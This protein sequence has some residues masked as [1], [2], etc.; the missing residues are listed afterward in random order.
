M[1]PPRRPRKPHGSR[2][3]DTTE[4]NPY[5][6][7]ELESLFGDIDKTIEAMYGAYRKVKKGFGADVRTMP[8]SKT[9]PNPFRDFIMMMTKKELNDIYRAIARRC[10]S[11]LQGG[12]DTKM[13]LLNTIM[14]I[15]WKERGM[16]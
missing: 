3:R 8:V 2:S 7:E 10:H 12:D 5:S 16:K 14:D 13:T 4:R 1:A 11:D 9:K 6:R 15:I